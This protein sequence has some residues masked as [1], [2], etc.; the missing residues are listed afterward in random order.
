MNHQLIDWIMDRVTGNSILDI[1]CFKGMNGGYLKV[2]NPRK[3]VVGCDRDTSALRTA[4]HLLDSVVVADAVH[5]P[6][7]DRAFDDGIATEIIEHLRYQEGIRLVREARRV[8]SRVMLSTPNGWQGVG[9]KCF[10]RE[11]PL[12]EHISAW[13]REE[14]VKLGAHKI[15]GLGSRLPLGRLNVFLWFIP[16]VFPYFSSDLIVVFD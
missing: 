7:R 15:R 16:Y 12:M 4:K 8:C 10:F 9:S 1:G 13:N 5:L 3:Y 11:H 2:H 6:F 14:F